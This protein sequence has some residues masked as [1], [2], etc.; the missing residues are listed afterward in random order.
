[1][2]TRRRL[3]IV[4]A[5]AGLFRPSVELPTLDVRPDSLIVAPLPPFTLYR[6]GLV[7]E[8]DSRNHS[9]SC[10][11]LWLDHATA[12]ELV[13]PRPKTLPVLQA[14]D[15][16]YSPTPNPVR[17]AGTICYKCLNS[18]FVLIQCG[19]SDDSE[20]RDPDGTPGAWNLLDNHD[21]FERRLP[22][23]YFDCE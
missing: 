5:T 17:A 12:N 16:D 11:Y 3:R 15:E 21:S 23:V 7:A 6:A 13:D 20:F 1:A 10:I 2:I 9:A 4:K 19:L 22:N 18:Q 14:D 8:C